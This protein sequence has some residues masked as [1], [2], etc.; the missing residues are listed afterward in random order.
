MG[1]L[2]GHITVKNIVALILGIVGIVWLIY[3]IHRNWKINRISS[4]PKANAYVIS[5]MAE[6]ANAEAGKAYVDPSYLIPTVDSGAQYKPQV[7]YR[8][9]VGDR[10]Y[11][12]TNVVYS[13]QSTYDAADT[14]ALLGQITPGSMIDV[15][16]NPNNPSEAYIYNGQTSWV[17]IVISVI[18]ILI[19]L[20]LA[21]HENRD[22]ISVPSNGTSSQNT[23]VGNMKAQNSSVNLESSIHQKMRIY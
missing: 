23:G 2:Q 3:D 5:S 17:G 8:Y 1:D 15:Y 6:P 18:L 4:W 14:K 10:D 16:Y 19:A 11:K 20:Y 12:S 22:L 21:Y 9:R 13:G 7:V